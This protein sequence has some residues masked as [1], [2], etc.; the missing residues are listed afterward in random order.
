VFVVE[1]VKIGRMALLHQFLV[2]EFPS[3]ADAAGLMIGNRNRMNGVGV[4]VV[5]FD[6]FDVVFV[7]NGDAV[8]IAKLR[9]GDECTSFLIVEHKS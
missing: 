3:F 4:L 7:E 1:N 6:N 8:I 5:V 2:G 9:K